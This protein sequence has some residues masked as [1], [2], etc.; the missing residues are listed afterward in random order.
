MRIFSGDSDGRRVCV[1]HLVNV[2][3]E[4]FRVQ[5]TVAPVEREV[6]A[7]H[8]EEDASC[9][10]DCVRQVLYCARMLFKQALAREER[11][12][13]NWDNIRVDEEDENRLPT[14][15]IPP[16]PVLVPGPWL[17]V[18]LVALDEWELVVVEDVVDGVG[19]KVSQVM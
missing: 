6:L 4:S 15:I 11:E 14:E 10:S 17:V 3:V 7:E 12:D 16:L 8:E 1:M 13:E 2:G 19:P 18:A 5:C 9:E